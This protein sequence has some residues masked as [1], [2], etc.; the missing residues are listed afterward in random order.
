MLLQVIEGVA[1][2]KQVCANN[3]SS[4]QQRVK[5]GRREEAS[6][7]ELHGHI[8][9]SAVRNM[10][11]AGGRNTGGGEEESAEEHIYEVPRP[12]TRR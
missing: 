4:Y 10:T 8:L 9:G 12:L 5:A 3:A 1:T 7:S 2:T 6:V 11:R